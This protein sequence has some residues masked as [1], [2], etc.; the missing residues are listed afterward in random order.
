M[1]EHVD[2]AEADFDGVDEAPFLIDRISVHVFQSGYMGLA[3]L[4]Y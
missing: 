2:V 1:I 4:S 3:G